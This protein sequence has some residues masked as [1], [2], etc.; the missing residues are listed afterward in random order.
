MSEAAE[1]I[2]DIP[3]VYQTEARPSKNTPFTALGISQWHSLDS[4]CVVASIKKDKHHITKPRI[5]L[6]ESTAKQQ[7]AVFAREISTGPSQLSAIATSPRTPLDIDRDSGHRASGPQQDS[8]VED[9]ATILEFLAW[10]RRKDTRFEDIITAPRELSRHSLRD[11]DMEDDTTLFASQAAAG[12]PRGAPKSAYQELGTACSSHGISI[13]M[14]CAEAPKDLEIYR[15][16]YGYSPMKFVGDTGMCSQVESSVTPGKL[17]RL[18]VAHMVNLDLAKGIPLLSSTNI[19]VAHNPSSNLKLASG[20]APVPLM[21]SSDKPDQSINVSL[22]TDGAPC[23]NHYDMFQEM[24]LVSILHKGATHD[25]SLITAETALE[26]AAIN[27]APALGLENEI[28]S[29]EVEQSFATAPSYFDQASVDFV[30]DCEL[31]ACCCFWSKDKHPLVH[32]KVFLA[33]S[34][35]HLQNKDH[36]QELEMSDFSKYGIPSEEWLQLASTLPPIPNLSPEE[37]KR[38]TNLRR[39]AG[40]EKIMKQFELTEKVSSQDHSI[41]ARDGYHLE[42][43]TY[44][45]RGAAASAE[46]LPVYMSLHGG[47]FLYG[48]LNSEDPLCSFVALRLNVLVLNLNYRHTPEYPYPTAWNDAEDAMIWLCENAASINADIERV[49]VGGSSAG[50]ELSASL[51]RVISQSELRLS[52]QPTILGQVLML[53]T[54]VFADCYEPMMRQIKDHSVSSYHQCAEANFM[55]SKTR[56]MFNDLL[57]VENPDPDDKRLNPGYLTTE[58]AEKMPPTTL[59][60]AGYDPL[61]DEGLLYGKL[62]ADNGV[63]TNVHVFKGLPHGFRMLG[64]KVSVTPQ[65]DEAMLEGIMW[66]LSKPTASE[67]FCVQEH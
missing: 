17:H 40:A 25:A 41:P 22:G 18:V 44:R 43:R 45:P 29:I 65:W 50:S 66:A 46:K 7:Q 8:E 12:T 39:D 30:I 35:A 31:G 24:Q 2:Q 28:G 38:A 11:I 52:P 21:A 13:T 37:L 9:A 55:D 62:L 3:R 14:H 63:P 10:G 42:A 34:P 32:F 27:G 19:S 6:L 5:D 36:C 26:M 67:E 59:L 54:V 4:V 16:T 56:N 48:T 53:P 1:F 23:S 57:K 61:R 33:F 58:E 47:G 60:I 49:V 15:N 51:T 20:I 64:D